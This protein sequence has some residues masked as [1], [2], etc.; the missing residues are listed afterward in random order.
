MTL[1]SKIDTQHSVASWIR[2]VAHRAREAD[3]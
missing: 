2:A 1:S 3:R